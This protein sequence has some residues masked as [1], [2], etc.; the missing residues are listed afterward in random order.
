M[1]LP[2]SGPISIGQINSELGLFVV[3]GRKATDTATFDETEVRWLAS[4]I[5]ANSPVTIPDD[6]W[7]KGYYELTSDL[8]EVFETTFAA[9]VLIPNV[10]LDQAVKVGTLIPIG[11]TGGTS[12]YTFLISPSLPT[13]LLFNST[14]GEITNATSDVIP[15]TVYTVTINESGGK[16]VSAT[17]TLTVR[18]GPVGTTFFNASFE[19]GPM[20]LDPV[21]NTYTI[22]GWIVYPTQI[23]LNG[24]DSILG[25]PTPNDGTA[26]PTISPG[27]GPSGDNISSTMTFTADLD[28]EIPPGGGTV[29]LRMISSGTVPAGYGVVH[30]PYAISTVDVKVIDGD[31]IQF[32]WQAKGGGDA[33]DIFAYLI[34]PTNGKTI[35]LLND[36]GAD[37]SAVVLWTRVVKTITAADAGT[38]KFVFVSGSWDAS[39]G[40]YL[41]ASL[42]VDNISVVRS[43]PLP[44]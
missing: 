31:E 3:P 28:P 4:K 41:G 35:E 38:Y 16:N 39:G 21:T 19:N 25:W 15:A 7:G 27:T 37:G 6:F 20:V 36:T 10:V 34:D 32:W 22:A 42:Y 11:V 8:N 18:A 1:T 43:K 9:V 29:S 14:N 12:P 33:Y 30:G 23:R 13:G 5:V 40:Q 26:A 17:F 24:L 2:A 44:P